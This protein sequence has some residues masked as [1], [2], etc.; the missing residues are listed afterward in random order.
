MD[1]DLVFSVHKERRRRG[2]QWRI[3]GVTGTTQNLNRKSRSVSKN[4]PPENGRPGRGEERCLVFTTGPK[5]VVF[6]VIVVGVGLKCM[7]KWFDLD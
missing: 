5:R 6:V 1:R 4:H 2:V 3:G 7:E